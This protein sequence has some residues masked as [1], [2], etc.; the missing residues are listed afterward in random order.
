MDRSTGTAFGF[1]LLLLLALGFG[2][3]VATRH[4]DHRLFANLAQQ[5]DRPALVWPDDMPGP[6]TDYVGRRVSAF[7]LEVVT[8]DAD[9]GFWV[10]SGTHKAWVQLQTAVE[11]PYSVRPGDLISFSGR[12]LPHD[13]DF[14]SQ[15]Y[16]CPDRQVSAGELARAPTHMAVR[17]DA[18]SF[19]VG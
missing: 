19:G 6:L 4:D 10:A 12:V 13:P 2:W 14:P 16:F 8:V 5:D 17:V 7:G 9:E 15:L 18:L 3:A 1:A 11:S